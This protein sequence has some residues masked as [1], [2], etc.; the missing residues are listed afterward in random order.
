VCLPMATVML[1]VSR[2]CNIVSL[3]LRESPPLR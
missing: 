2:V 1:G 3:L